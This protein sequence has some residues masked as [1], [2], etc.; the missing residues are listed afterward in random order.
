M[1][2]TLAKTPTPPADTRPV[3]SE[4]IGVK[5]GYCGG[6][7]HILGH[8]IKVQHVVVW[9]ERMGMSPTE[10][11]VSHPTISLSDVHAALAYY[12]DHRD[13]IDADVVAEEKHAAEIEAKYPSRLNRSRLPH[14]ERSG[15]GD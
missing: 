15:K 11:V 9:H 2:P 4:H 8:R 7:P 6:K 3:I 14:A 5:A 13:E 10:I 1:D 12:Y